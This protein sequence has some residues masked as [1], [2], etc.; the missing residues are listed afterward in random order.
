MTQ[1]ICRHCNKTLNT[2]DDIDNLIEKNIKNSN[3]MFKQKA[4]RTFIQRWC[5]C[6]N[7]YTK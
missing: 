1:E 6:F 5:C 3:P 7:S 2:L 4:K